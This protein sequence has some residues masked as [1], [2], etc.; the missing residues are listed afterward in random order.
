M[1][2]SP[3]HLTKDLTDFP[4]VSTEIPLP[5]WKGDQIQESQ[6]QTQETT[7]QNNCLILLNFMF[8]FY[9][10]LYAALETRGLVSLADRGSLKMQV[11]YYRFYLS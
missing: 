9:A 8:H 4:L 7:A 6:I 1:I 3:P 11:L 5:T 2:F 10:L